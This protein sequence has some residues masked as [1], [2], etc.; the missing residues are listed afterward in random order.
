MDSGLI[1]LGILFLVLIFVVSL[2]VVDTLQSKYSKELIEAKRDL[3][4][5]KL[6]NKLKVDWDGEPIKYEEFK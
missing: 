3:E 6:L 4:K 5:L 1:M 2:L